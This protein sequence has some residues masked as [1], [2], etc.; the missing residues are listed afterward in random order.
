MGFQR[1]RGPRVGINVDSA[2][3]KQ[4]R[5]DAGLSLAQ[6]AG[7]DLTRQAVHLIETGKVRPTRRSLRIIAERLGV[8]QSAL[9]AA[10]GPISD[11]LAVAELKQLCDRHEHALAAE[12]AVLLITQGGSP[13][14]LAFAHHYAGRALYALAKPAE[15]LEHARKARHQF[16]ALDNPWWAAESMDWEAIALNMLQDASALQV[17]RRA[18]R[19]YRALEPRSPEAEAR[20]LTHLGTIYYG[21]RNYDAGRAS[22]EAALKVE[23]GVRELATMARVYHGLGMC[24][25]GL[26]DSRTA[27]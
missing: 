18:L 5:A 15:A 24:H 27:A 11:E 10:P 25:H 14:R 6:V 1:A 12:Q 16:A 21:R 2:A 22:Y 13:E 26:S 23:G 19:S 3:L 9:L 20:M 4:A 17:A 8:S 7:S